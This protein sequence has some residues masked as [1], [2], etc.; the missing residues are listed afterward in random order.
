MLVPT[1]AEEG[2][3]APGCQELVGVLSGK[4]ED[5]LDHLA[6]VEGDVRKVDVLSGKGEDICGQ[7]AHKEGEEEDVDVLP[8][9]GEDILDQLAL[10]EGEDVGDTG[11]VGAGVPSPVGGSTLV[12]VE[13]STSLRT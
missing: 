12:Q 7:V 1:G 2:G 4:G 5:T 6:R 10:E 8:D 13:F 11:V 3:R 9:M